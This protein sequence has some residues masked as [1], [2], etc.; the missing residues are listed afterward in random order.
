MRKVV[1]GLG[2]VALLGILLHLN[3]PP[4]EVKAED[5]QYENPLELYMFKGVFEVNNDFRVSD[6]IVLKTACSE[7]L[8]VS[9]IAIPF[10]KWTF[11]ERNISTCD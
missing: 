5:I 1:I 6:F 8:K 9:L 2:A 11:H 4:N 10:Q 3:L 7:F